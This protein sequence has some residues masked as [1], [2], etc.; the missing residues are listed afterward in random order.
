MEALAQS[1]IE[2][3]A[4]AVALPGQF[5]CGDV[6]VLKLLPDGV[7]V[8]ALDGLGHGEEA[9]SAAGIARTILE[10]HAGE[11]LVSLI[12]R[13]H[14]GLRATRGVVM[15]LGWFDPPNGRLTWL[16]VGNVQGVLLRRGLALDAAEEA[17][18]LRA[19]VV[20]GAHLPHLQAAVLP[21]SAGDTLVF[22]TDGVAADF[23]RGLARSLP[24]LRAAEA[25]LGRY[26]KTTDD[27]LV[28]VARFLGGGA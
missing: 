20:G 12:D 15:S 5:H 16:G 25:I 2:S 7:L 13:C 17:L 3:G 19:G 14:Q 26:R 18:L 9:A 27:A 1:A 28:V 22:V 11:P 24:P 8:A 23:S 4:A 6:P 21:V 10:E